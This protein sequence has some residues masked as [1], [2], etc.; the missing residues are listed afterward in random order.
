MWDFG[1]ISI[2]KILNSANVTGNSGEYPSEDT[3]ICGIIENNEN[4]KIK[5]EQTIKKN[6]IEEKRWY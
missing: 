3:I 6:L 2:I 4:F 5:W 1:W